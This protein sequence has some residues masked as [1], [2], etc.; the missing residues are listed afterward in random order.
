MKIKQLIYSSLGAVL[1]ADLIGCASE[2]KK[3]ANLEAQA[4]VTR[5][6]AEKAALAR[7]PGGKIKSGEIENEKGKLIW[8][9]DI[10]TPGTKDVTEV[11]VDAVTG[12][13]VSVD[14]ETEA[15]EAKEKEKEKK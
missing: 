6:D 12:Q 14:K 15:D 1:L 4:K 9:F 13:I 3:E 11:N 8:S 5:A 2:E 10:A 7:V